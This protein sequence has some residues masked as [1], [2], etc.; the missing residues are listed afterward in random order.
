MYHSQEKGAKEGTKGDKI[1]HVFP[2]TS[3][4]WPWRRYREER[5]NVVAAKLSREH[6]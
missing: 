6:R 1:K 3:S 2:V 5:T 4:A